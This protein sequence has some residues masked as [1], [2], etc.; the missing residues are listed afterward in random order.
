MGITVSAVRADALKRSRNMGLYRMAAKY[1]T[2]LAAWM[3]VVP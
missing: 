3:R 2:A 1:S